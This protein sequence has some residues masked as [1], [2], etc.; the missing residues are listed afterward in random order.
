MRTP[1]DEGF[2]G[3]G[4]RVG[5][6]YVVDASRG[7]D[8]LSTFSCSLTEVAGRAVEIKQF[9]RGLRWPGP[10]GHVSSTVV[11]LGLLPFRFAGPRQR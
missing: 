10:G 1:A 9:I 2:C 6:R 4:V 11:R 7:T 8:G 3:V 5:D